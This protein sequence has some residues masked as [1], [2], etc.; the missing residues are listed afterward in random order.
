MPELTHMAAAQGHCVTAGL[1][2]TLVVPG[3]LV[4]VRRPHLCKAGGRQQGKLLFDLQKL[5]HEQSFPV[6]VLGAPWASPAGDP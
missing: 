6:L 1:G 5:R 2:G 3:F 4:A